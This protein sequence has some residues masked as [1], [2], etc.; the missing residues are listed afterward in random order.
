M[1]RYG[2]QQ[3][4]QSMTGCVVGGEFGHGVDWLN[5]CLDFQFRQ[6]VHLGLVVMR[7]IGEQKV[8]EFQR[9]EFLLQQIP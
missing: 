4:H 7:H 3:C 2:E 8:L 6:L 1:G 5:Q 9:R